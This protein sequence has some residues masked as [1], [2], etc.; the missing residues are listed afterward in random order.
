MKL[1]RPILVRH[2]D[3]I[4]PTP[5]G[6]D[7]SAQKVWR[8]GDPVHSGVLDG[9]G[10]LDAV[11][12]R[13]PGA[14]LGIDADGEGFLWVQIQVF[15][16]K[17]AHIEPTEDRSICYLSDRQFRQSDLRLIVDLDLCH[18]ASFTLASDLRRGSA[19][20][21]RVAKVVHT[22]GG[23]QQL[24][25]VNEDTGAAFVVQGELGEKRA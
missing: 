18:F 1:I 12:V 8:A 5:A 6:S 9:D 25:L 16:Q 24:L 10:A 19:V 3:S 13:N 11:Q 20:V 15:L 23:S 22:G 17:E 2:A 4:A 7:A 14:S 21:F